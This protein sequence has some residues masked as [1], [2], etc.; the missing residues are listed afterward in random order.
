MPDIKSLPSHPPP[1]DAD[2]IRE[3]IPSHPLGVKPSGN[4]LLATWSLR[5]A[6]GI[7][8]HLPDELILLL[9]EA[10]DGPSLLRIGRTCKAFY[11]FTRAEELWKALFVCDSRE[12]FTWRGTWRSTYLNIP[13]SKVPMVDCSQ[14]FSDSLYR[15]FNCAHISLDPYVSKIPARN[16]IAR[17][18]EL[19]PEEFQAKWTDRPFI[20][21]E[22]VK[23]WP[24]YKTWNVG[25]LLA[26]YGKT[27]FRAEAVDWAM[28]TY[29]DY[30]AD[31]SDESPLY[32]FDRS[33]VSKMGLSV[34]SSE[35]TPDASYWPPACF[36]EDF[37][38]VLGDDR[39]DHQW[40]II[41]PERSGSKFHKDP[42]ATSA[43]NAVL[44]GP[45]YWIMF[46]S[47]TKQPPPPG[48]FVSDD[49]SEVTSPLSIAEWLL[50]FH[51][52]ARR[53]P[54]CVEGICG[55]GEI[56][57]VPSGW[58]HLVVNLE[59]SIAITQNFI[60]RGH[61]GAALDFLSNKPDQVSGFRK[62]VANPC[63][64]FMTGM[65]EAYPDLLEQ[66]W[67]ELQKKSE[68]KKRKW[69]D[70]V[71][72]ETTETPDGQDTEGGGFSFGFGDDGS[73]VEVP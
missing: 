32:L 3:A 15:P 65:R 24:A 30:M 55:E 63:E 53:T 68:G 37:F 19:S 66:A 45:K 6:M 70:I 72:G 8:Q 5:N 31:N 33:F 46:P 14:L 40:L 73:D 48:V 34:G 41:G 51:A 59:P 27:K 57:H 69:E 21:T 25:S 64:R 20:L 54:G 11:A 13:A 38:S 35:T 67:N 43:W 60:P 49:Q 9:L 4:A 58:W 71:H 47:S 16:Q 52:E 61:L 23:A 28:R 7:F 2:I 36:A 26:R 50:G 39:P 22:P 44:R 12:D 1:Q 56:L 10:F 18:P 62:N 29:G 42:N 17:L